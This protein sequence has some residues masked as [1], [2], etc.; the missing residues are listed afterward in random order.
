MGPGMP[1]GRARVRAMRDEDTRD[2]R[3]LI[4]GG[5]MVVIESGYAITG[6]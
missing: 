6:K 3:Y 5:W 2:G 1:W 4:V